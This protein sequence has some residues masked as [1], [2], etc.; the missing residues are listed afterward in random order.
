M[1]Y[2][3]KGLGL[4]LVIVDFGGFYGFLAIDVKLTRFP[5]LEQFASFLS[6]GLQE[7]LCGRVYSVT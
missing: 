5:Y 1:P 4:Y 3:Q 6:T 2:V 7:C